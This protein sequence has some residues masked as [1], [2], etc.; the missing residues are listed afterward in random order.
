M[1]QKSARDHNLCYIKNTSRIFEKRSGSLK[2]PG[3]GIRQWAETEQ[4]GGRRLV[5]KS[6]DWCLD[7]F[8]ISLGELATS[9]SRNRTMW[10]SPRILPIL[11]GSTSLWPG[12]DSTGH[13]SCATSDNGPVKEFLF[14]CNAGTICNKITTAAMLEIGPSLNTNGLSGFYLT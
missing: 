2:T 11:V 13:W 12:N 8:V 1:I 7:R 9:T 5:T 6:F 4:T 10:W 3:S 14:P